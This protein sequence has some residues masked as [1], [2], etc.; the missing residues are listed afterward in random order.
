MQAATPPVQVQP[1]R[2]PIAG[3]LRD[4]FL[5]AVVP[6]LF[7][8][9]SKRFYS[10]SELTALI[11]A[12][13]FP[14]AK[15]VFEL[16]RHRQLDPIAVVVALGI[17]AD[18]IAMLF[19]GSVRLLL[20]RESIFTGTFGLACFASLL[21]PRPMMFYF[22]RHF[23]AGTDPEKQAR[24]NSAWQFPDVRFCHR[25]IT[26]VWGFV[27]VGELAVR[28]VL[29]YRLPAALVLVLSPILL[30]VLTTVTMIWAFSYG[31]RVRVRALAALS[32]PEDPAAL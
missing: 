3:I 18:A 25:L 28:I 16:I 23:I 13:I 32:H 21:L 30:G 11:A 24:F 12:S 14:V 2:P 10:P 9:L 19:G 17:A 26:S 31:H 6:V 4:I 5:S 7:Y 27:F 29:I 15:S 8:K 1:V 22:G 20:L